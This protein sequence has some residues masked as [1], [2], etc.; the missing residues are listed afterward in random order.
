VRRA[1]ACLLAL[2]GCAAVP[3][4]RA[5][6][7]TVADGRYAMGTALELTFRVARE[8][9][10]R[11]LLDGLYGRVAALEGFFSTF[12]PASDVSRLN[13]AAGRGPQAA[14]PDLVRLLRESRALAERTEG[15]FDPSV[16]PLVALWREAARRGRLP[17]EAEREA[18][19][20]RVGAGGIRVDE[21]SVAL[22]REGMALD[23]G[24]VAKGYALDR[25]AER[26]RAAG[27]ESALLSF[28][29][30]SIVALG[31]PPGG[32]RWRLL[33]RDGGG[34]YAG[35][36]A[37]RDQALS[38][39]AS[40]G[41]SSA[42]AGRRI[43]HVIDP[44]SGEPVGGS[45]LAAVVAPSA[46]EAEAW[47]TALVVLGAPRGLALAEAQP[48]LEALLV[49]ESGARFAS[50]GFA[51]AARFEPLPPPRERADAR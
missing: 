8:A 43:G 10:G 22:A 32:E 16:G 51:R 4:P 33:L 15:A 41:R 49:D 17:S 29:E 28:G 27:V 45:R 31:A 9:E 25:L 18:A 35:V 7:V 6:R 44:R 40:F 50:S 42:V 2:A 14:P 39:S 19:R 36:I 47:S 38:V 11:V 26:L 3:A 12:D 34:G 5:P 13:A 24:G 48:G 21:A 1:A 46:T 20:K 23:L 37:L 30:S